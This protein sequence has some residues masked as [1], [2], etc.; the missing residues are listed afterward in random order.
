MV[1]GIALS[2]SLLGTI[3][4]YIGFIGIH[5]KVHGIILPIVF[6]ITGVLLLFL[7]LEKSKDSQENQPENQSTH[8]H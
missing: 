7:K 2:A 3:S 8:S 6:I 1:V 5:T 4:Y